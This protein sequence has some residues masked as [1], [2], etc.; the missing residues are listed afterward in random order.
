[1]CTIHRTGEAEEEAIDFQA[2]KTRYLR[3]EKG[4]SICSTKTIL[5]QQSRNNAMSM[6]YSD[7]RG[8]K[9]GTKLNRSNWQKFAQELK[10]VHSR[11]NKSECSLGFAAGNCGE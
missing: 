10:L 7:N 6:D 1:M 11:K 9:K 4:E 2:T 3:L 5:F 8:D